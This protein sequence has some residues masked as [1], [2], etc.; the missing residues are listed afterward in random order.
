VESKEDPS[1]RR[2]HIEPVADLDK[3]TSGGNYDNW[4]HF[5]YKFDFLKYVSSSM[6]EFEFK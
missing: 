6:N 2:L 3:K 4:G 1:H 5:L